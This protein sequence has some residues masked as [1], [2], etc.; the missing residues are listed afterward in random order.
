MDF[1][2]LLYYT[3]VLLRDNADVLDFY[4]NYFTY[5]LV[6]E[7]QDTNFAQHVIVRQLCQGRNNLCVVGDDAQSIYSFRG[8]NIR[9]I[10]DLQ[11]TFPDLRTF[12]LE[13]NYRSTRNIIG[14]AN[15]LI[16]ANKEQIQKEVFSNN[17][18]RRPH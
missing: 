15:S 1:D 5:I 13:E 17:E 14:A 4:R 16:A 18:N 9:N 12:K 10:L 3:N 2:D 8:A 11:K 6:D 7:Y